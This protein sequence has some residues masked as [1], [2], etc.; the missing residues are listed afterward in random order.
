MPLHPLRRQCRAF[1]LIELLVVIAIIAVLIG[2]LL[3]AVQKVREA[4]AR[5]KCENNM[6]QLGIA[7]HAYHDAY[8]ALP[9]GVMLTG[10]TQG[11]VPPQN[12]L[13]AYRTPAFGPNWIVLLLPQ[14]EQG[15]VYAMCQ[16]SIADYKSK[17][18]S[19][20]TP[21]QTWRAV[22]NIE[23]PLLKCP[24]DS[25]YGGTQFTLNTGVNTSWAR[26]SYAGNGGPGFFRYTI[27]GRSSTDGA[28][29]SPTYAALT[30]NM[31][32]MFC[33]NMGWSIARVEDGASNTVMLNHLRVGWS[34]R[35]R[36]GTWAMGLGGAS[37]TVGSSTGDCTVP[38][39]QNEYSDD[40]EDCTLVRSDLT[41]M[42]VTQT[43]GFGK[44][45]M[46][47]SNDNLPQNWPNWQAQARSP[48]TGGV[49]VCMADGSVRFVLD[50]ITEATW[51]SANSRNDGAK[52]SFDN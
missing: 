23:L 25:T 15:S 39:D 36:R 38:N 48:H 5:A 13:S 50:S 41:S 29:G 35:D 26:G 19:T 21:D 44:Y 4:A 9:A 42:G 51:L 37:M 49:F 27:D 22:A 52:Y 40:I 33:I 12:I 10:L 31:G 8:G 30:G 24:S 20:T 3:P 16:A 7:C 34:A 17:V 28:T 14:M 18:Y 46:G 32:G 11:A 47:C 2:L 6:K 1:T 43:S 45:K